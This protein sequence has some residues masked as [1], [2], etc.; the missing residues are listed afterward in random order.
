MDKYAIDESRVRAILGTIV[1][2][3]VGLDLLSLQAIQQIA[4]QGECLV[5]KIRLPYPMQGY[6]PTLT[7][8]ITHAFVDIPGITSVQTDITWRVNSHVA[9]KG[10][11]GINKAI[12]N[13]IAIASGKGGV[14]KSTVACNLALAIQA[15]GASVGLLDAD[16]YGPSQPAMLGVSQ[17]KPEIVEKRLK[18][19]EVYG[20]KTMSMGY[21][22]EE[23]TPMVWRGP[24]ISAALQ[25]LLNDTDWG[26]LDYLIV[27]LPPGTGDIQL[28]LAQK[29]PVSGAVIVTTPQDIALL[30]AKKALI[31]FQKVDVAVL[32]VV[33]NM[34]TYTCLHCGHEASIF[35]TAGALQLEAQYQTVLLGELPL[36]MQIRVQGDKGVPIV[37][38]EPKGM[39]S[40]LYAELSRRVT[41]Q[42]SLRP[43]N[44]SVSKVIV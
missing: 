33:E 20:L 7:E 21:L 41:G 14:G 30:D 31:M 5:L 28:T 43:R 27:D 19:I 10:V 15:E 29:I 12:K 2:P 23:N 25:Q 22:V 32:G 24:M 34:G 38:A 26:D 18:P 44:L 8:M 40:L 9:Q 17:S 36:N 6:V 1:L 3:H 42:L 37:L 39:V 4:F 13:I 11:K 16:I 35:G